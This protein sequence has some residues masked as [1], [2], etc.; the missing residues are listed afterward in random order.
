MY[1]LFGEHKMTDPKLTRPREPVSARTLDSISSAKKDFIE[2]SDALSIGIKTIDDQHKGLV[3]M[4]NEINEGIKGGW[5]KE[6]RDAIL[7]KL[8]EY[9]VVH[10]S[11]EESLMNISH[12]SGADLH[13]KHHENLIGLVGEYIKKYEEDPNASNYDLLFFLKRWLVEHILKDDKVMGE[14]LVK[15]GVVKIESKNLSFFAKFKK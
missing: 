11:T 5:G 8:V 12:Y 9:T 6:A 2:W 3:K 1:S 15:K 14:Y 10:F 13:K 7:K 4:V